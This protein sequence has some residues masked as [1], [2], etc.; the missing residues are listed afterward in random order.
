MLCSHWRN[1]PSFDAYISDLQLLRKS[2]NPLL[3]SL[4]LLH[5]VKNWKIQG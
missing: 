4:P 2:P 3:L 1:G 5:I